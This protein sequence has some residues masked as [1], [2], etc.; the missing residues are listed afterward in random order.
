[1]PPK[2][3]AEKQEA[4]DKRFLDMARLVAAWSKDPST[5]V[6]A[7]V[8]DPDYRVRGMGYNGFPAGIK[9]DERLHDRPAKHKLVVHAET[10]AIATACRHGASFLGCTLVRG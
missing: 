2:T 3:F 7:V 9:D 1:M 4:W 8:V 10:N 5:Q 6:G